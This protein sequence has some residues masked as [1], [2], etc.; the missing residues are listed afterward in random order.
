MQVAILSHYIIRPLA[1][2]LIVGL[3]LF[4]A[5]AQ[6]LDP[7][8]PERTRAVTHIAVLVKPD[9]ES[10]GTGV[11]VAGLN[12][13]YFALTSTHVVLPRHDP[14]NLPGPAACSRLRPDTKLRQNNLGGPELVGG[15]VYHLGSDISLIE[16]G[17]R[18]DGY[19][20]LPLSA[21]D[22]AKDDVLSLAGFALG[23]PRVTRSGKVSLLTGPESTVVT[24]ILTA[25]GMSGGP[26]LSPDGMVVGIHRG[27][28]RYTAGFAHMTPISA[29]RVLLEP[30]L[31][32][33]PT[34]RPALAVSPPTSTEVVRQCINSKLE[35]FRSQRE[36]FIYTDEVRC[37]PAQRSRNS[38]IKYDVSQKKPGYA[39]AGFVSHRDTVRHGS[40]GMLRYSM[41]DINTLAVEVPVSCDV[42]KLSDNEE[43][44][45]KTEFTGNLRKIEDRA[46][47]EAIE[48]ACGQGSQ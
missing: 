19:S 31:P 24:D 4:S 9:L 22:L 45:A 16:L 35:E 42:T 43:G 32:Q 3:P 21:R 23:Y 11:V 48:R 26:Y 34:R 8:T 46:A 47:R 38:V 40:V 6:A 15:C 7:W 5:Y 33:I 20:A 2:P 37:G 13:R 39:I 12:S 14:A 41:D 18:D 44:W 28:G 25:E 1:T 17:P 30:H 36:P 27:G 29:I 10:I